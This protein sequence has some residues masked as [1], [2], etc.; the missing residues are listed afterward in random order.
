MYRN[1]CLSC[2]PTLQLI[3]TSTEGT[4][5]LNPSFQTVE[6]LYIRFA[7]KLQSRFLEEALSHM[8][9]LKN[10][11]ILGALATPQFLQEKWLQNITKLD[12]SGCKN[13]S[14]DF[15]FALF[16]ALKL[17]FGVSRKK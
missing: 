5:L 10:V 2:T 17:L 13:I 1:I 15:S 7:P 3:Q 14:L 8:H 4:G 6:N 16:P 12:I 11:T 9:S